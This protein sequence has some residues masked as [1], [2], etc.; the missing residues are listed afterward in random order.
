[1]GSL[2]VKLCAF[3]VCDMS[4]LEAD[5]TAA[6]TRT[7]SP[8]GYAGFLDGFDDGVDGLDE[9]GLPRNE[10]ACRAARTIPRLRDPGHGFDIF[11][12]RPPPLGV[13][14][15]VRPGGH[16]RLLCNC[17]EETAFRNR[18]IFRREL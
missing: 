13:K 2:V 1:M 5:R 8:G 10:T 12:Q 9:G 3:E 7:V 14:P 18:N 4:K 11:G 6:M 16:C 17:E 15:A